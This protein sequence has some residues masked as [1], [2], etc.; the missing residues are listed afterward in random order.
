MSQPA[1]PSNV[2]QDLE[3]VMLPLW[4]RASESEFFDKLERDAM[5]PATFRRFAVQWFNLHSDL[6]YVHPIIYVRFRDYFRED[7][8]LDRIFWSRIHEE[9]AEIHD[10][11]LE[12]AGSFRDVR[13]R[14]L[15][16]LGISHEEVR[17]A[18]L[19]Y[20]ARAL[21]DFTHCLWQSGTLAEIIAGMIADEGLASPTSRIIADYITRHFGT[22]ASQ[23][24]SYHITGDAGHTEEMENALKLLEQRG[25][26]AERPG[27]GVR[28][29]A[30][31]TIEAWMQFY[32]GYLR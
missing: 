29:A 31:S 20:G 2:V 23:F 12:G 14:T 22:D 13:R 16:G 9:T 7:T 21:I 27:F 24:W 32:N 28:Y 11:K 17:R 19:N 25:W 4:K 3:R 6:I 8:E 26:L 5:D 10:S 18:E 15:E 30:T 1:Q